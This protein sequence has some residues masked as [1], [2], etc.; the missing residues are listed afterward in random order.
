[1][2]VF[3]ALGCR[4]PAGPTGGLKVGI[5]YDKGGLGDKSFNDSADRGV[6]KAKKE[7]GV[8]VV[9]I[10]SKDV[11]DYESNLRELADNGC[12]LV[13]AIGFN[14]VEAVNTVAKEFPNTKF[15]IVDAEV[16]APNVRSLKFKEEEGSYLVGYLAGLMTKTNKIGFIGGMNIDLIKKFEFGYKAGAE[17]ANPKIQF[18]PSKYTGDWDN[19]DDAKVAAN[20]MYNS[21]ADIIYHAAGRAGLGVIRAAA[22][23][24]KFAI[25]VDSDQDGEEPG[26]VLTSMIK[27]VDVAVYDTIKELDDNDFKSGVRVFDLASGGVGISDLQ[28]TKDLIGKEK[29]DKLAAAQKQIVDGDVKVPSTEAEWQASHPASG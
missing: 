11:K 29:L 8:D 14:M 4:Q 28:Y 3:G 16:D 19:I 2:I 17:A 21:G 10:E 20:F 9:K 25:G 15:A 24:D 5:V 1:M 7:L 18:V 22:D 12:S 6:E 23:N 26:H 13:F 27:H